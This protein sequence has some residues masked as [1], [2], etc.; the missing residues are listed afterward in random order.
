MRHHARATEM[1]IYQ[2]ASIEIFP[3][4]YQQPRRATNVTSQQAVVASIISIGK[5]QSKHCDDKI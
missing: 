3:K 2:Y 4:E 5:M 1:L